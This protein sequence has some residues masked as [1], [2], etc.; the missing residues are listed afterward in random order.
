[1]LNR[2]LK[3]HDLL[4]WDHSPLEDDSYENLSSRDKV[5]IFKCVCDWLIDECPSFFEAVNKPYD[6][7]RIYPLGKDRNNNLYWYFNDLRLY[8]EEL[9]SSACAAIKP[10]PISVNKAKKSGEK[11]R[12]KIEEPID[13]S[14]PKW[15]LE[16]PK[17][18]LIC[19]NV[20]EWENFTETLKNSRNS[21]EK[22]LYK[23]II[24]TVLPKVKQKAIN[25]EKK[26]RR[27]ELLSAPPIK[28]SVRL[29][30]KEI[31]RREEEKKKGRNAERKEWRDC[32]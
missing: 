20:E 19:K 11:R 29:Q 31:K 28:R 16:P 2:L 22:K 32:Y 12:K 5:K 18:S 23:E 21:D 7:W 30:A 1:M 3:K 13:L 8:K 6:V 25:R 9:D 26:A 17:W 10:K 24:E 14:P 15:I 27:L 4:Y